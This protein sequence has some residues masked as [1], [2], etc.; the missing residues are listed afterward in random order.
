MFTTARLLLA[1]LA[2][3]SIGERLVALPFPLA[4]QPASPVLNT[5][6]AKCANSSRA[7]VNIPAGYTAAEKA[8]PPNARQC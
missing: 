6:A 1:H 3:F 4:L 7:V 5:L 2:A 8:M